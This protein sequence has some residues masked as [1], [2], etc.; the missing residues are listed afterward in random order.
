MS[1]ESKINQPL[2]SPLSA[3]AGVT[4][5]ECGKFGAFTF[6]DKKLCEQCYSEKGS[7][8]PEFG[9]DDLWADRPAN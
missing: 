1:Q 6:G 7:C 5:D 9:K 3:D 2:H 4:C 8:C